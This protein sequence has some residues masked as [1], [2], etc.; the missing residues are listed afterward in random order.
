MYNNDRP[1]CYV[2][3]ETCIPKFHLKQIA[4]V[5]YIPFDKGISKNDFNSKFS[6]T[7]II[8]YVF[9]PNFWLFLFRGPDIGWFISFYT[10]ATTPT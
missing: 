4:A 5:N 6:K 9:Y 8:I 1:C 7:E 10:A 2:F 3:K